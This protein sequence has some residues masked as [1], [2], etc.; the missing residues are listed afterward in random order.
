MEQKIVIGFTGTR[1]GM[2]KHQ[3]VVVKLFFALLHPTSAVHGDCIGA[4]SE[5]HNIALDL[6]VPIYIFPSNLAT[7]AHC[8]GYAMIYPPQPALTRNKSI[9][10]MSNL[11]L[12]CPHTE[13]EVLR[14]GTWAT[15]RYARKVNKEYY[16]IYPSGKVVHNGFPVLLS[17][18]VTSTLKEA[19]NA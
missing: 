11:M 17:S 9:V 7:R 13:Q 4:D 6:Q 1:K 12:A 5:F 14:S 15:I 19:Y 8:S 10:N 16:I 18:Q 2:S 3:E